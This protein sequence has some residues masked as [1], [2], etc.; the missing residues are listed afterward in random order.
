MTDCKFCTGMTGMN[1][2]DEIVN[3]IR[4]AHLE[5]GDVSATKLHIDRLVTAV[6]RCWQNHTS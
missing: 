4:A 3:H 2:V 1:T 6:A 5:V